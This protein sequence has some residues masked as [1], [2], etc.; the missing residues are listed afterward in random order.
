MVQLL[1]TKEK[2]MSD[3]FAKTVWDI[4]SRI[5]CEEHIDYLPKSAKRPAVA[6][7]S[8]HKAWTLAVRAFPGTTYSHRPDL[9]HPDETVEVEVDVVISDGTANTMF[10]NARLGVMDMWFNPIVNPN[11]RQI[12][13]TRQRALVKALAFAGLALNLWSESRIPVGTLED[14]ISFVQVEELEE[15]IKRSETNLH[16]FLNWAGVEA[17]SEIP[18]ENYTSA[19]SLLQAKATRIKREHDAA[20][21]KKK[22]TK[23]GTG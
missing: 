4:L 3:T 17:L 19:L 18:V 5:D 9:W 21:A 2:D 22:A 12:N 14:P 20:L 6:Y 11:A 10:T 16:T 23:G 7:L 15:L 1:L 13:D 8:W